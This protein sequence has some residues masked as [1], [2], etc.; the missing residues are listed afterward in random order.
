[1]KTIFLCAAATAALLA[2][3]A[4]A[5]DKPEIAPWGFDAAGMDRSI[6]PGEGFLRHGGGANQLLEALETDLGG[7]AAYYDEPVRLTW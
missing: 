4:L 6:A 1:M 7:G 5:A 2:A 3:P